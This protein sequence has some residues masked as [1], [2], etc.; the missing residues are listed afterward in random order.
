MAVFTY[1]SHPWDNNCQLKLSNAVVISLEILKACILSEIKQVQ[2]AE[3]MAVIGT[4]IVGL[5]FKDYYTD[6]HSE[7]VCVWECLVS[8]MQQGTFRKNRA[9]LTLMRTKMSH[10]KFITDL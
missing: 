5:R 9:F 4:K 1:E 2:V 3:F 8:V 6:I 10:R 7:F